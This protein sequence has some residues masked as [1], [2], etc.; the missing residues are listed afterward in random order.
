MLNL[1]G[2][3]QLSPPQQQLKNNLKQK[4]KQVHKQEGWDNFGNIHPHK[5]TKTNS[6]FAIFFTLQKSKPKL[7]KKVKTGNL[8]RLPKSLILFA[9]TT[10]PSLVRSN[11][12][13]Q[14]DKAEIR[15]INI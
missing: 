2:T 1:R 14:I 15:P 9:E 11:C 3:T 5:E 12:S 8:N 10:F 7:S 13:K 4:T 6:G